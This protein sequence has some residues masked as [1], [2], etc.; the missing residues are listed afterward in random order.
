MLPDLIP[1]VTESKTH[2][3]IGFSYY[4]YSLCVDFRNLSNNS[5]MEDRRGY[6]RDKGHPE[7]DSRPTKKPE[8]VSDISS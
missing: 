2:L 8:L 4:V 5:T 3:A 6:Y 1:Q 7:R